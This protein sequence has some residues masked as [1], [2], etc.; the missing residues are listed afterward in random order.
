V[1]VFFL[2]RDQRFVWDGRK[3]VANRA[4]HGVGFEAACEAFF[5]DLAVYVEA[6]VDEESRNAVMGLS[7]LRRLLYVVYVEREGEQFRIISAREATKRE[8]KI[9]ENG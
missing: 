5:D 2:Y 7:R 1:D 9:Y 4:K 6:A 3:A 8:R